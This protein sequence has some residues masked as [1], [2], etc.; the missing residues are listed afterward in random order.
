MLAERI[1]IAVAALI[2]VAGLFAFYA[3]VDKQPTV[4]RVLILLGAFAVGVGVMWFTEAGRTFL[5]FAR[6]ST[7]EAKRVVWPTR[8]ETLQTTG[9]VFAFVFVMAVFLW[10]VDWGLLWITQKLLGQGG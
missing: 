2:A 5:A 7:E 3:L 10:I 1:K 8:K 6:E 9:V 4:V